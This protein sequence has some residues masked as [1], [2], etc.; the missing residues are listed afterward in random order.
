MFSINSRA[1]I[2]PGTDLGL[3]FRVPHWVLLVIT[4]KENQKCLQ[5]DLN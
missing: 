5:H 1:S 4:F 2:D 3:G